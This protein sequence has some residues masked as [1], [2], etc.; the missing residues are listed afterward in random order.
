MQNRT[1]LVVLSVALCATAALG[2]LD[3]WTEIVR[4][5]K[6]EE[7]GLVPVRVKL[8][9]MGSVDALVPRL[10]VTAE[11]SGYHDWRQDIAIGVGQSQ[12][13]ALN[14]WVCP[15][16]SEETCTAWITYPADTN[17]VN[18]TD[19]VVVNPSL[20]VAAEIVSPRD[21]EEPGLIPVQVKLTN[22]GDEPAMVSDVQVLIRPSSYFDLRADIA[23]AAGESTVVLLD[24]WD[25][26]GGTDTC[27][28]YMT[29][30]ADTNDKND[31]DVVVVNAAGVSGWVEMEPYAGMSLAPLPSPL[32]GNVLHI[33]YSLT[34]AGPASVTLFDIRGRAVA[35]RDFAGTRTGE[36]P[37]DLRR[38]SG[39]VYLVRL[40]D[41][42]AAITRKLVV[43]R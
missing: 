43:Q 37:L 21:S 29:C 36:L 25:Y 1:A 32:A 30:Y 40:D 20:D 34:Q 42:R 38:L 31:I 19:V 3:V 24:S 14:P 5:E 10:D 17:H 16:G 8:T 35:R 2:G 7:P 26:A 13:V 33:E 22:L 11:P 27:T 28:A 12:T 18:D 15:Y 9:N 23:I 41:G 4:P 6:S 39:G